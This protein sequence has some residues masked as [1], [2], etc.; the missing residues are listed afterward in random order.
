MESCAV[1]VGRRG[2]GN[3]KAIKTRFR[4]IKF[5]GAGKGLTDA[6]LS[7]WV[8]GVLMAAATPV[9]AAASGPI[10]AIVVTATGYGW[11]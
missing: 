8:G 6:V 1:R 2:V 4:R 5:R 3:R 7:G 11:R 10:D 9:T